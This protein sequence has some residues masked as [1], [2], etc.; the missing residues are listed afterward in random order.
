M[1][2]YE[3]M[4][5]QRMGLSRKL[6]QLRITSLG[7]Y[8]EKVSILATL[9]IAFLCVIIIRAIEPII[10]IRVGFLLSD[11]IGHFSA[12]TELYLLEKAAGINKPKSRYIDIFFVTKLVCN[13]Y[14]LKKW[15]EHLIIVPG[16]LL[17]GI[18]KINSFL[19]GGDAFVVKGNDL[20]TNNDRDIYNLY[21]STEP[22][23]QFDTEERAL[24]GLL[25]EELGIPQGAKFI[26]L[27]VRDSSYL[28]TVMPNKDWSYHNY[29]DS[30]I[31]NFIL[32][33]ESLA[34][35]GFFVVRVGVKVRKELNTKHPRIIDYACNGKRT[36]FLDLYLAAK[37]EFCIST[38][39]GFDALPCIFRRPVLFVNHITLGKLPT[40]VNG[41]AITKHHYSIKLKRRLSLEE[42]NNHNAMGFNGHTNYNDLE[43]E[44][45][46]NSPEEIRD[47]CLEMV[48]ILEGSCVIS[49][50]D[51][52]LQE[53]FWRIFLGSELRSC[54]PEDKPM[55]GKILSRIGRSY[56]REEGFLD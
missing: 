2:A 28:E 36:E 37:C 49:K 34:D 52:F 5:H 18:Y 10:L 40:Y 32:A 45:Q 19:P 39:N 13:R 17:R 46:E 24:G 42:I 33:S 16:F 21:A 41:L 6:Q 9:P 12:N 50:E 8:L 15:S 3:E 30:D 47:V 38:G 29:R 25:M 20:T 31:D 14:L 55:H 1:V 56:L 4:D 22:I 48:E 7:T 26:T 23:I 11:R 27:T 35:L 51:R 53:K 43:I 54:K 44:L